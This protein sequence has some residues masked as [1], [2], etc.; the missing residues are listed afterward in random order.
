MNQSITAA[1]KRALDITVAAA[2]LVAGL[3]VMAIVASAVLLTMGRPVLFRQLRPGRNARPFTIAKF[4]TMHT[5]DG[6]DRARLTRL[7][8]FLR[9][10][11]LD[12]LPQMWN[13]LV[14]DMSLVGPRPLLMEYLPRYSE[15]QARRHEVRPGITGLA[16][17]S[18][19][20]RT[21]WDERLELDVKYVEQLSLALD[22][23]ILAATFS[24]V[25]RRSGISAEGQ[26]T[27]TAFTGSEESP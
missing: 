3:P 9:S 17:I 11:S 16:Q 10:T 12:E 13:V 4:R 19:R 20:N 8:R 1:T 2:V 18:G 26:A 14:G 22:L 21:P 25:T 27:M 7:G 5:G 24:Q 15:R 6:D 23:R